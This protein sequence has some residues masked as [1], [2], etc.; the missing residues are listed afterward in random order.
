MPE[1]ELLDALENG[2]LYKFS[3]WPNDDVPP[4]TAGVYTIWRR[5]EFIYVGMSGRGMKANPDE[6]PD[7]EAPDE[8]KKAKGLFT[9]LKSHADGK[10][11]GDQF[12]VYVCDRFIVP[13]LTAEQQQQIGDNELLLDDMTKAYIHKHL[14]YRWVPMDDGNAALRLE[15]KIQKESLGGKLPFLNPAKPKTQKTP[16]KRK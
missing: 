1:L 13:K 10:R 8:P 14:T 15:K 5:G 6:L 3:A 4:V 9:R 7:T 16:S 11:S 12:C 2:K